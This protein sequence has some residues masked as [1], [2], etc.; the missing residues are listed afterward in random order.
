MTQL[1]GPNIKLEVTANPETLKRLIPH[2]SACGGGVGW[3][4]GGY[5]LEAGC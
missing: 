5:G 4:W 2:W 1:L 3:P